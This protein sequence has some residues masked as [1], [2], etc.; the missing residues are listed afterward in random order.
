MRP[1]SLFLWSTAALVLGVLAASLWV[2]CEVGLLVHR[3]QPS[4]Q[5][6]ENAIGWWFDCRAHHACLTSDVL[7]AFGSIRAASGE[8]VAASKETVALIKDARPRV[9]AVLDESAATLREARQTITEAHGLI[10]DLRVGLQPLMAD[11]D[12]TVRQ[13]TATLKPLEATL[14]DADALVQTLNLELAEGSPHAV[15]TLQDLDGTVVRLNAL[16]DD[17]DVAT[18]LAH[19]A[20]A[21]GHL[22]ESAASI[23]LALR[24]WREKAHLLKTVLEKAAN[25]LK[26][27]IPIRR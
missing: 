13:A 26:F 8:S 18:T 4:A 5:L 21:S 22:E 16:L 10:A 7:G 15:A 11:A 19:V 14:A 6:V 24:P 3:A 27:T 20:G 9:N 2:V 12:R 25:L 1:K 17:P 23:D